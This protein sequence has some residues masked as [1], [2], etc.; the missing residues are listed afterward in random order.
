MITK[1]EDFLNED[2]TPEIGTPLRKYFNKNSLR[3]DDIIGKKVVT[4]DGD[5]WYI[6]S[7][8]PIHD[9]TKLPYQVFVSS[10]PESE[11]GYYVN[12]DELF[13]PDDIDFK[14]AQ[15]QVQGTQVQNVQVQN[16]NQENNI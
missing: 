9:S 3:H 13:V 8:D 12:T 1:F 4:S 2:N 5:V 10:R 7:I 11:F 15:G 6:N 14:V 16:P